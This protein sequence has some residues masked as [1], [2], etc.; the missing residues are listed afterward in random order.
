MKSTKVMAIEAMMF[1]LAKN[2][3]GARGWLRT[4]KAEVSDQMREMMGG[5]GR[6]YSRRWRT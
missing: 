6:G 1:R 5:G 3:F 2:R 4:T